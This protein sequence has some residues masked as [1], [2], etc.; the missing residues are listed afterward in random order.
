[1]E[2]IRRT[3]LKHEFEL[4]KTLHTMEVLEFQF[5]IRCL[6]EGRSEDA[7]RRSQLERSCEG[8]RATM[9]GLSQ[10]LRETKDELARTKLA[11]EKVET[12]E[13]TLSD[14]TEAKSK[15]THLESELKRSQ[16][17]QEKMASEL[18]ESQSARSRE[19]Q[20]PQS[21]SKFKVYFSAFCRFFTC[22]N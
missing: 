13:K 11:L 9:S 21:P 3:E 12:H 4:L 15:I 6:F 20:S 1:M 18:S 5:Q 7:Q 2:K 19:L 14:L 22:R 17:A 16:E 10:F 8:L